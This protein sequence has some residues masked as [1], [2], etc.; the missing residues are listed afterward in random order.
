[1][2]DAE[3]AEFLRVNGIGGVALEP[4][5]EERLTRAAHSQ[6]TAGDVFAE[7]SV[8]VRLSNWFVRR[9]LRPLALA[10]SGRSAAELALSG[11]DASC[12]IILEYLGWHFPVCIG[13]KASCT[14]SAAQRFPLSV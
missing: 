9:D 14:C 1:M 13:L 6:R 5:V 8:Q 12:W 2:A 3:M 7:E 11:A 10:R 4:L